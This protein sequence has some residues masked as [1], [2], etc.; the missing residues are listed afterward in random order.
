MDTGMLN[1]DIWHN[2]S[3]L[4]QIF[5][6]RTYCLVQPFPYLLGWVRF[7]RVGLRGSPWMI[8]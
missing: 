5:G 7:N 4:C 6:Y 3:A 1:L 2:I 8:R